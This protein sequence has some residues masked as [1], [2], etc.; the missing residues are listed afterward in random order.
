MNFQKKKRIKKSFNLLMIFLILISQMQFL[1]YANLTEIAPIIPTY[2]STAT[3]T[4]NFNSDAETG[5]ITYGWGCTGNLSVLN[6]IWTGATIFDPLTDGTYTCTLT[7]SWTTLTGTT[8]TVDTIFPIF[9]GVIEWW[10]YTWGV[11][12]TFD[13][14]NL[15]WAT[16]DWSAYTSGDLY[17][18]TGAHTF[19][20][21]DLAG[22]STWASFTIPEE[23][24]DT[25]P[26]SITNIISGQYFSGDVIPDIIEI[27]YSWTVV[28]F[29]WV[30][31]VYNTTGFTL[32]GEWYY[33]I[34]AYDLTG[35]STAL[36]FT[37][38]KTIPTFTGIISWFIYTTGVIIEFFDNNTWVTA[39]L[40]GNVYTS[41]TLITGNGI[42]NFIV[43]DIAGNSTWASFTIDID[44]TLP[45]ITLLGSSPITIEVFSVYIDSWASALDN[46]DGDITTGIITVNPVNTGIVAPYIVTYNVSDTAGNPAIQVTRT[47]NVVDTTS[48]VISLVWSDPVTTE[49]W[50]AYIDSWAT[51]SDN[52]D[53]NITTGIITVNPVNTFIAWTYIVT[54]N[55][56][57]ANGNTGVEVTRTV[58]VVD[59]IS[60]IATIEYTPA[61]WNRTSG[62]VVAILSWS[63]TLTGENS[64]GNIFTDNGSFL[65]TFQDLAGNTGEA[66][67]TVDRIDIIVPVITVT[68]T[69]VT[70]T[71]TTTINNNISVIET[72]AWVA[73]A[74][75]EYS[76]IVNSFI[77]WNLQLTTWNLLNLTGDIGGLN[78]NATYFYIITI[79]DNVGNTTYIT[80]TFQTLLDRSEVYSNIGSNLTTSGITNN[81]NQV[82]NSNVNNFSGLYFTLNSLWTI[83]FQTGLDLTD[84]GT[85]NF[86]QNLGQYLIMQNGFINFV[87][88]N[89]ST[90][91]G[92]AFKNLPARLTMYLSTAQYINGIN[93]ING[94]IVRDTDGTPLAS[95]WLISNFSCTGSALTGIAQECSFDTLHFTSFG[96]KPTLLFVNI[97]SSNSNTGYAKIGDTITLSFT[98]SEDLTWVSMDIAWSSISVSGSWTDRSGTYTLVGW[99]TNWI[100]AISINY[101]DMF[102]NT[103]DTVT[104]SSWQV[105]ID[106]INPTITNI[107]SGQYFS[108]NVTPTITEINYSGAT[109]NG[110]DYTS[111]TII[112]SEWTYELIIIDLAGNSTWVTFTIDTTQPTFWWVASW[113][114]YSGSVTLTFTDTATLNG[115]WITSGDVISAE[116]SYI[117]VVTDLADNSTWATFI[118]DTTPP[119]A[120]WN[121]SITGLTNQDVLV[122]LTW[123]I[124]IITW[125]NALNYTFTGNWTF[126]FTFSDL[127]GNTGSYTATVDRIDKSP[128]T[129][130]IVYDITGATNTD[131]IA[132]ITWFNKT[133]VTITSSWTYTFTGNG[134]YT[135]T[136]IDSYGN[137]WE[138]IATVSRID[139]SPVTGTIVY[140]ITWLTNTDVIASITFNKTWVIGVTW[141][142]FTGNWT[143]DFTFTDAY[144]NTWLETA[145]VTWID[146]LPV[147]WTITYDITWFTNTDVVAT[148]TFNKTWVIG[149]T[150]YTF[151]WNWT[152]DFTFTDAYGNTW[153]ETATVTWID[154]TIPT[155]VWII[156]WSY[157]SGNQSITF[158]DINLSWAT[159]NGAAYNSGDVISA[160]WIYI[161]IV[162][163]LADNSTWATFTID[164][165]EPTF[166]W[167]ISWLFYNTNQAITFDDIN[168]SWATLNGI[169]Y[170]S[171]TAITIDNTYIFIATDR[172]GNSTWATFLLDKT[173]PTVWTG[174][175]SAGNT[176]VNGTT[177]YYNGTITIKATM[178]DTNISGAT[179]EYSTGSSRATA[180]YT[181]W[182]W[183]CSIS[184]LAPAANINVR[185]RVQD[186]A[187]NI[188]TWGI[189]TYIYDITPPTTTDN[190]NSTTGRIDVTVILSPIDI[191]VGISGTLYCIDTWGI[192]TPNT[193][194]TSVSVTG[195]VGVI[196][197]KY[198]RYFSIDKLNNIETTNTSVQIHIDK[199]TP[200]LTGTTIFSSNNSTNTWYAKV[201]D[202][203]TVI[204][205]SHEALTGTPTMTISWW[206]LTTGT[207]T[208][209]WWNN[210][211]GTFVMKITDVQGTIGF[212][213]FMTDLVG[214]TGTIFASSTIIFDRT[215]PAGIAI[216]NPTNTSY[217]QWGT[218]KTITWNTWSE[219]NFWSTSLVLQYSNDGRVTLHSTI[220]T[221]T[222]NDWS[223]DWTFPVVDSTL[224]TVKIIA[225]DLAGNTATFTG[226][227]FVMDSTFPTDVAIT[228]PSWGE[229]FKGWS[230]Y[231][232]TWSWGTDSFLLNK[233]VEYSTNG[234]FPW[235]TILTDT[236]NS[237]S[238]LWTAPSINSSWVR[239]R[240]TVT[241]Q[242]WLNK[243]GQ[244]S[245]FYI[246]ST[247]PTLTFTDTNSNRRNTNA[248]WTATASD[249]LAGLRTTGI[250]YR[251]DAQFDQY[252]NGWS[253]TVPVLSVDGTWYV[254][255]CV[256]D[257]AGNVKT[258][259][260]TYKIDKTAPLLTMPADIITNTGTTINIT[261]NGDVAGISW[262]TRTKLS[263]T[264]TVTFTTATTQDPVVSANTDWPFVLQVVVKDNANNLT[265]WTINFTRH[266][267][268]PILTGTTVSVSNTTATFI[269]T[270]DE[271][272]NV[273]YSWACW[274]GSLTSSISGSN[275]TTFTLA[276][277]TYSWCQL[278]VTDSAGNT[279]LRLTLPTFTINYT[280]PS[281]WGWGGGWGGWVA[282]CTTANLVCSNG[283][284]VKK[285]GVSCIAW[286]LGN[287]C[288]L[289]NCVDGDYSGNPNDGLCKDPTKVE[290]TTGTTSTGTFVPFLSPFNKELTDAYFYAYH[291]KATTVADIK[292]ANM[293]GAL[294]RSHLSKMMSEYAIKVLGKTPDTTRKCIFTDMG[295]QTEEFKKYAIMACQLG[296]MGLKTDGTPATTFAPGG[297][298]NR[299]IFGTTLSRALW[300]EANN[301]GKNRY[302]KHLQAL[303][304]NAIMTQTDKPNN[305]ELRWYVMLMMMRA[306][307]KLS[308]SIYLNFTSLRWT[309]IF[310]PNTSVAPVSQ[311]T[312]TE[313]D[314]IKNI[315]KNYQFTE[316]Y[317]AGQTNA[318]VKYLQYFLKAK[319]IYTGS[320]NGTNTQA[321]LDALFQF[322][323]TNTIVA[324]KNDTWAW[325]LGPT[326]RE[327]INPLLQK[328][329]NP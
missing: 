129:G 153:L 149:V 18:L 264:W 171:G 175:I 122:T 87:L 154:K 177:W 193:L 194:W 82:N 312:A 181:G 53:G 229:Y 128:V 51:A 191:W 107:T 228:F 173:L 39:T 248:T 72:G 292:R 227:Q 276:N 301:G 134:I 127:A 83:Q 35:N 174:I 216:T 236:M 6:D 16:I 240:I 57:D 54:Y 198:V 108:G 45:V 103:G 195:A 176:G 156:S 27:N 253:T 202:T 323:L 231:L 258:G 261:V 314:F 56:T 145:T 144:G 172:A 224:A 78:N 69:I 146:K 132:E 23:I 113:T 237:F 226:N 302:E 112:S 19:V 307:Q 121:Y 80:G 81:F 259:A 206:S 320:I 1:T 266:T 268:A 151:T 64:T 201:G 223:F 282:V 319:K 26:P 167:V 315:N 239:L 165:T 42:Y 43:T 284:Y 34:T 235:T 5:T 209:I 84:T 230:W 67:A 244:T 293:T 185:F 252:C 123:W 329:L 10:V 204:F 303:K 58:N 178:S 152:Y 32:T 273:L 291:I 46:V 55:I 186:I 11:T 197:H 188:N 192:C 133:G 300:W 161:F 213:I 15:S 234:T 256:L 271:A 254:Y 148:I 62:N 316:G 305:R 143:Y 93:N 116:W 280:A 189:K 126:D 76:W 220:S 89:S 225:T 150:W 25:T 281:W 310:V 277:N 328:L 105:I 168:L 65:F 275:T 94:I 158:D 242:W 269:F 199:E 295:N 52:Y 187:G 24:T 222:N 37:I 4:Y 141:Y 41:W 79:T 50:M 160:E 73:T 170:T 140:D 203:I 257:K 306:D 88:Y 243:A 290:A 44:Y 135:F 262:Y 66:T 294:I 265:T 90:D 30:D 207:V 115:S 283:V 325:Y 47:V 163:D 40:S 125:I 263:G 29:S 274:T 2:V 298:V 246:D 117:L 238:Y 63:E 217:F 324:D 101:E 311:F 61:S 102:G 286:N 48:P 249:A 196:T 162:S 159:L 304:T 214:N 179:C 155:F 147:S 211:S 169:A 120:T 22:N 184:W 215:N 99:E 278:N 212:N 111:W 130:T 97:T 71:G 309:K 313:L 100:T 106:I 118:I 85:Q 200:I 270:G 70:T 49:R 86:L 289:D 114:Y 183:Y 96:T 21:S 322:Q 36:G 124:E 218:L 28:T 208:N 104:S 285:D 317:T 7:I 95:S 13:D 3:P 219:I 247:K 279:S 180:T 299:A 12:I 157:Y 9:S 110:A 75:L 267:I 109:L 38:D 233:I 166:A 68:W 98:G 138:D 136:Y 139:K 190:A 205:Q 255:A 245:A 33:F 92:S 232:I 60:P 210:Y 318:G 241:D 91:S 31:T 164:T 20:V 287:A 8:F 137:T 119:T 74:L 59:T 321:T 131:V 17:I 260:Q 221:W 327:T 14:L 297:Q 272:W 251:T 77:T 288:S 142:T 326:T 250:V 308:K 182:G 296:L